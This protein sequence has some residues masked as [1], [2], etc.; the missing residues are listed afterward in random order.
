MDIIQKVAIIIL[1]SMIIYAVVINITKKNAIK[2]PGNITPVIHPQNQN[3]SPSLSHVT[4][5]PSV[6]S[7]PS[8][9]SMHSEP[10][11]SSAPSVP[12]ASTHRGSSIFNPNATGVLPL[13]QDIFDKPVEF[14][15]DVTNV[16]QF[17]KN[18]PDV[19]GKILGNNT[20]TNVSDW[21]QQSK[22][23]HKA[24]EQSGSGGPIQAYNSENTLGSIL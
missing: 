4:P 10:S 24:L 14:G 13:N 5:G 2:T 1:C 20:I 19:L 7:M 16:K 15:S 9:S 18:N 23:M 22:E 12:D 11:V 3:V 17:Y 6:S 8:M 21:E